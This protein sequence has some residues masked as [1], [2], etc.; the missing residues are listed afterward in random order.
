[1]ESTEALIGLQRYLLALK[2]RWLPASAVFGAV[3][4]LTVTSLLLQKPVYKAEGALR[5]KRDTTSSLT[6]L[7][8]EIGQLDP[9]QQENTPLDTEAEVMRSVPIG[10][11]TITALDLKDKHGT[12]LKLKQFLKQLNVNNVKGTDVLQISYKDVNPKTAAAVVNTLMIV[13]LENN[14]RANRAEATAAREFIENQLPQAA[15]TMHQAESALRK[16][17][18][19][20]K[21]V[22][23]DE[24]AKSA[25]AVIE[26]LQKLTNS[27][28]TA[29]TDAVAQS[30]QLRR[31][32]GMD[33][34]QAKA[35]T[36]LSQSPA[37]QD[38]LQQV[39]QV[40]SQLATERSR[41]QEN[42]PTIDS[43][44]RKKAE[45]DRLLQQQVAG[46]FQGKTQQSNGN[47]QISQFEQNL[48][49][50]L[51]TLEARRLGLA[52]QLAA[53][54]NLQTTYTQRVNVLPGLEQKQRELAGNSEASRSTYS[55]LQQKLQE[56][57]I[58]ENQN[59]GNARIVSS[60]LVPDEPIAPR[61][62]LYLA[63]GVLLAS[64]LATVTAISLE[65]RDKSI[66]TADEARKVFGYTLLGM[67]PALKRSEKIKPGDKDLDRSIPEIVVRDF[68]RS[69]YSA[70]YRMLQANLKFSSSVDKKLKV[71]AVTSSVPQEGK[72]TVCTNLA[73][74]MAQLGRKVL[75]VDADMHRPFQHRIWDLT[76]Q[77]GLSDVIVGQAEL[78]TAIKEVMVNLDVLTSGVMPPNPMALLDSHRMASLI[79]IFSAGYD[80]TII[81]TPSLSVDADASILGK[82][83][84]GVLLIVRP[85]V[86]DSASATFAKA[87]LEHSNQHVLGQV[88]NGLIPE[89][90]PYSYYHF[91]NKHYSEESSISDK[92]FAPVPSHSDFD[93]R[94]GR[95]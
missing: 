23:L 81:D 12:P 44:K 87:S 64:L 55:L 42:H 9:L 37:V 35:A 19:E 93:N 57:R 94:G 33:L 74:A 18:E 29:L 90:E 32:L 43:L 58:A 38:V 47:L 21:V 91:S 88:I 53:L 69:A 79:E 5:F 31:E 24:E 46:V 20:N 67:I 7:G 17:K 52:S 61:K 22:A 70:A 77:P 49:A 89:N 50:E 27:T 65:N 14:L 4:A 26:D 56:I 92:N 73:V 48:T 84:D 25:V 45:L 75:L 40:N 82:M 39:Q 78:R 16:F 3:L 41:F 36:S 63:T 28:Q 85:G 60:A 71:I 86:V 30:A 51:A 13:Y 68:P 59:L 62:N 95:D 34:Q 54:S 76:N 8:K 83:A 6:G 1:M 66:R 80:F 2:R 15:A 72:S 10:S 11:K